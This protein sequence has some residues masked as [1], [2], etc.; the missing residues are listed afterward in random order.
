MKKFLFILFLII[1]SLTVDAQVTFMGTKVDGN[2]G[3]MISILKDKGFYDTG[4]TFENDGN[5]RPIL[6]GTF[7]G[8]DVSVFV[9]T[10]HRKVYRIYLAELNTKNEAEI[11]N[12]F[13][14][15]FSQF[16][17]NKKYLL[18]GGEKIPQNEDISYEM[19]CHNKIY[20]ACFYQILS[21]D[22]TEDNSVWFR[23]VKYYGEYYLTIYYDNEIN[24]ANGEDL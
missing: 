5:K 16:Y 12:D 8:E 24:K 23:I 2:A 17:N 18:V 15:L 13:N 9:C 1:A 14:I 21:D 10:N 20:E 7:N 22:M 11:I 19:S 3:V 4:I 6:K